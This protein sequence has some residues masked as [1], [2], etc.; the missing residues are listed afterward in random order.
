MDNGQ[1]VPTGLKTAWE[2]VAKLASCCTN[3]SRV[4]GDLLNS[5]TFTVD[6]VGMYWSLR[7]FD[8]FG[9][10]GMGEPW[11][12]FEIDDFL[13]TSLCPMSTHVIPESRVSTV[14]TRL[15]QWEIASWIFLIRLYV[16]QK[17]CGFPSKTSY[18]FEP[19]PLQKHWKGDY[20]DYTSLDFD[21]FFFCFE[22]TS[23]GVSCGGVLL[24]IIA[25]CFARTTQMMKMMTMRTIR[26]LGLDIR[27][28]LNAWN[29]HD[30]RSPKDYATQRG[31]QN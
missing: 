31:C 7:D 3:P 14:T 15:W 6:L 21:V 24:R 12:C 5:P 11:N 10:F 27:V 23:G 25:N 13:K 18:K 20:T 1:T 17:V 4:T 26:G 29:L 2:L 9:K 19:E 28:R 16:I 30:E 8:M 22:W